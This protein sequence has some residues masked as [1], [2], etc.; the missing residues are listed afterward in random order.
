MC[1]LSGKLLCT[2]WTP[3]VKSITPALATSNNSR[4]L[5]YIGIIGVH[6]MRG[7]GTF[8]AVW[9]PYAQVRRNR[10]CV[11]RVSVLGMCVVPLGLHGLIRMVL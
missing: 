11:R 10:S 9:T 6:S 3:R 7:S 8:V 5:D 4:G 2:M 1:A